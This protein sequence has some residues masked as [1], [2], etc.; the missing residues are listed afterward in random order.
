MNLSSEIINKDTRPLSNQ[1]RLS[2]FKAKAVYVPELNHVIGNQFYKMF[3]QKEYK[4][5]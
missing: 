4:N 2:Q 1:D 5:G 3:S